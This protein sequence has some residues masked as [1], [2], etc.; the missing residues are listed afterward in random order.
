MCKDEGKGGDFGIGTFAGLGRYGI[1]FGHDL[2][3][4]LAKEDYEPCN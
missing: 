2:H 1:K 4:K 3:E